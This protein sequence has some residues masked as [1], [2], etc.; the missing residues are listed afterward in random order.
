MRK[1]KRL[2][3]PLPPRS[4]NFAKDNMKIKTCIK[5]LLL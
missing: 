1:T 3:D 2:D 5:S 4:R